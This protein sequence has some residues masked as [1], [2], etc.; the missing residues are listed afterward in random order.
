MNPAQ[1]ETMTTMDGMIARKRGSIDFS[2]TAAEGGLIG[3]K[4]I[5]EHLF[6][7]SVGSR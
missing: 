5:V 3:R 1:I 6:L 7:Q 2:S 4:P